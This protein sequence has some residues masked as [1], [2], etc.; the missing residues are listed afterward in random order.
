MGPAEDSGRPEVKVALR[1]PVAWDDPRSERLGLSRWARDPVI[2]F[3]DGQAPKLKLLE[4][5]P[6]NL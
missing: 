6:F 4:G 2:G 1:W 3:K 5:N